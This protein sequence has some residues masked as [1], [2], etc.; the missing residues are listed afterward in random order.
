MAK[1]PMIDLNGFTEVKHEN[2]TLPDGK[3]LTR[4]YY[5]EGLIIETIVDAQNQQVK[6]RSNFEWQHKGQ[7]WRP[8]LNKPNANF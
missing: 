8:D 6:L 2:A 3:Q 5:N 4:V 1:A 7:Q